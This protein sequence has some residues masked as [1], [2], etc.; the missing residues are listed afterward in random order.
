MGNKVI[1]VV[2]PQELRAGERRLFFSAGQVV[3]A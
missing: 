3:P 1:S 2:Q